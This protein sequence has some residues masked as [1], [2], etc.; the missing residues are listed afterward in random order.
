M[1]ET[2]DVVVAGAGHN[3][4]I[5]AAYLAKAG[6]KV[7]IVE[8]QEYVGGGVVTRE[9]TNVPGFKHDYCSTW[10]GF[11]QPNPL[12]LNDELKLLSDFGLEY[13]VPDTQTAVLFPDDSY[14]MIY[15][16][17]DKTCESIAQFSTK[18]A[19]AYRKFHKWA[20]TTLD[21]VTQGMYNPP[22]SFG[23][24]AALLD[25]SEEGRDLLRSMMVSAVDIC[26]EWFEDDRV[27]IALTRFASEGMIA[28]QTKGTGLVLFIFVPLQH[29]YGGAIPVG[30][31]GMLSEALAK[32]IEHHGGVVKTGCAIKE[33]KVVD[34]EAK[35]VILESGEEILS[36]KAL[37]TNFNIKQ[38]FPG[39]VGE[40]AVDKKFLRK[41]KN[42]AHSDF[43]A[44]H[45]EFALNE[46]PKWNAG[47]E[48]DRS[49]W[50]ELRV[51]AR[52]FT[53]LRAYFRRFDLF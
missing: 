48:I 16:D 6:V 29:K 23:T 43:V 26:N 27:K 10:H 38:V 30:G 35:G 49:I 25:Q 36:N 18:D 1:S 32:C 52:E 31:S 4:L 50:V 28:P 41:V 19:E 40:G 39:M 7:C 44:H 42:I 45:Q 13:I 33:F 5:V 46:A 3:G 20:A 37:V 15:K 11:I 17:V 53:F 2:Y 34:G 8:K 24:T 22:A 51:R 21:M 14:I 12:I 47:G 9:L